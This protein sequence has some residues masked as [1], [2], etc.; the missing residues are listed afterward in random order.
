MHDWVYSPKWT[1]NSSRQTMATLF[2]HGSKDNLAKMHLTPKWQPYLKMDTYFKMATLYQ[3]GN[4]ILRWQ[5]AP[6]WQLC[7][8]MVT[9]FK[10]VTIYQD[11]NLLQ[12][13]NRPLTGGLAKKAPV[14]K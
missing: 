9:Y 6:K 4:P 11:G 13:G 2:Q 7:P 5:P 12:N 8:K 3:D 14:S 1:P 10:M